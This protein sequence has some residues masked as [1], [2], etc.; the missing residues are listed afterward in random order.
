MRRVKLIFALGAMAGHAVWSGQ[1]VSGEGA[2]AQIPPFDLTLKAGSLGPERQRHLLF[3]IRRSAG[4]RPRPYDQPDRRRHSTFDVEFR[5]IE[6]LRVCRWDQWR[7]RATAVALVAALNI[8]Q[9]C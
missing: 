9:D 2:I 7:N 5:G 4:A 6:H 8:C 1:K 3:A